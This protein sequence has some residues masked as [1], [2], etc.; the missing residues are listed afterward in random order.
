MSKKMK[1]MFG[2]GLAM[3]LLI[4]GIA[5]PVMADDDPAPAATVKADFV[6]RVA[7]ILGGEITGEEIVTAFK[8]AKEGLKE[9]KPALGKREENWDLVL[10]KVAAE[11]GVT[12]E[13]LVSAFQQAAKEFRTAKIEDAL[14]KAVEKGVITDEEKIEIE[15]W[16][17]SRPAA[18]DK[19]LDLQ[20]IYGWI[21]GRLF[22]R[23]RNQAKE[24]LKEQLKTMAK[25]QLQNRLSLKKGAKSGILDEI[26]SAAY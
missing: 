19:L 25:E 1:I 23:M 11:L 14:T 20:G 26:G 16:Y 6:D 2:I 17:A 7:E 12:K 8:T 13:A 9:T 3:V 10:E 24:Q 18:V 5:I 22:A 4:T 21:K 15:E